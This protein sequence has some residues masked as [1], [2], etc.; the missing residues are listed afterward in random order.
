MYYFL[1]FFTFNSISFPPQKEVSSMDVN[2]NMS[3]DVN[4]LI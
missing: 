1:M 4:E 3:L 2:L